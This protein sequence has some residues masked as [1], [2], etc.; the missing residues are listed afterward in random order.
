MTSGSSPPSEVERAWRRAEAL[1]AGLAPVAWRAQAERLLVSVFLAQARELG[2]AADEVPLAATGYR[3]GSPE[4]VTAYLAMISPGPALQS[5][6]YADRQR[7]GE[8][9]L[10]WVEDVDGR[11]PDNPPL[12][13][14]HRTV[15]RMAKRA[16]DAERLRG[17]GGL[18]LGDRVLARSDWNHPEPPTPARI[19]DVQWSPPHTAGIDRDTELVDH[20]YLEAVKVPRGTAPRSPIGGPGEL[21]LPPNDPRPVLARTLAWQCAAADLHTVFRTYPHAPEVLGELTGRA[22]DYTGRWP[23]IAAKVRQVAERAAATPH[24]ADTLC[25]DAAIAFV[26]QSEHE[27]P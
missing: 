2:M 26:L 16:V 15:Q 5:Q 8:K 19:T 21:L 13:D 25:L 1:L 14:Q 9:D 3:L 4:R 17:L 10:L 23:A 24:A 20:F 22:A 18:C 7:C 11:R 6:L 27:R 12:L